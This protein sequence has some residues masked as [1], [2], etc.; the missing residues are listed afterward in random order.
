[1]RQ[2]LPTV[3][4]VHAVL[5]RVCLL[6]EPP[7]EPV[8]DDRSGLAFALRVGGRDGFY[9]DWSY[10][11]HGPEGLTHVPMRAYIVLGPGPHLRVAPKN[12]F[13]EPADHIEFPEDPRF[14]KT[15]WVEGQDEQ[16]CRRFLGPELRQLL[17]AVNADPEEWWSP[18]LG[19]FGLGGP[20]T[21]N[22]GPEGVVLVRAGR[23]PTAE[24]SHIR[25]NLERLVAATEAGLQPAPAPGPRPSCGPLA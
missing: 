15:F 3:P 20:W 21:L 18:A 12:V 24:V 7:G 1:M 19:A 5:K 13:G 9:I 6:L 22:A 25:N 10:N 16:A 8:Q 17:L 2:G 4:D 14:S 23:T 11:V